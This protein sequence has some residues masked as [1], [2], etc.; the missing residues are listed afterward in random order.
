MPI[1]R[2]LINRK[3]T[4]ISRDLKNLKEIGKVPLAKYLRDDT[5]ETLAEMKILDKF[6][7]QDRFNI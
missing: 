5:F 6:S 4:L 7:K 2:K 1:D 3:I